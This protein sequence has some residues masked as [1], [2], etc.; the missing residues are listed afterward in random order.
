MLLPPALPHLLASG[1]Q[2]ELGHTMVV[3][4]H[5]AVAVPYKPCADALRYLIAIDHLVVCYRYHGGRS[6]GVHSL[7]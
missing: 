4:D 2:N 5:M 1:V 7:C 3:G 6:R